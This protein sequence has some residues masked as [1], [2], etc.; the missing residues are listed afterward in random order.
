MLPSIQTQFK[1][2]FKFICVDNILTTAQN[3]KPSA[4]QYNK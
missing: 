1:S 3:Y 2:H 4:Y